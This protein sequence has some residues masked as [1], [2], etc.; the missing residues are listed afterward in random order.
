MTLEVGRSGVSADSEARRKSW[1]LT[2]VLVFVFGLGSILGSADRAHATGNSGYTD[3]TGPQCAYNWS[4]I[5][6]VKIP[7]PKKSENGRRG[8]GP[9]II[10]CSGYA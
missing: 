1:L 4:H 5:Y 10:S 2:L 3:S 9:W 6:G 7:D 8:A